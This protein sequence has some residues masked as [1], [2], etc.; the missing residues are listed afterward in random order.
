[1]KNTGKVSETLRK[2]LF[3]ESC[4]EEITQLS[5][6]AYN[7]FDPL[8]SLDEIKANLE[9]SW[10]KLYRWNRYRPDKPCLVIQSRS[11]IDAIFSK[12]YRADINRAEFK[13]DLSPSCAAIEEFIKKLQS[14][15]S[16]NEKHLNELYEE[17]A[18]D[19]GELKF[20]FEAESVK[21]AIINKLLKS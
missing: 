14:E 8:V 15:I 13:E 5:D 12:L 19:T 17:F 1:M 9:S 16:E 3:L 18:Q 7:A 10:K 4:L 6:E 2:I 21:K 11:E 20:I